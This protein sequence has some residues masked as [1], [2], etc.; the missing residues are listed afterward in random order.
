MFGNR[1]A[2][3]LPF[4]PKNVDVVDKEI[5]CTQAPAPTPCFSGRGEAAD[6]CCALVTAEMRLLPCKLSCQKFLCC[7]ESH[8]LPKYK[9]RTL[10]IVLTAISQKR[11]KIGWNIRCLHS[12][13]RQGIGHLFRI[14]I[15]SF[16]SE[17]FRS[18]RTSKIL[19]EL[20]AIRMPED[21]LV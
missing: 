16:L 6:L 17:L 11:R 13:R 1:Y 9:E 15:R 8:R 4:A 20:F 18:V 2:S 21:K 7:R 12:M 14:S 3:G 19:P 10:V 5:P